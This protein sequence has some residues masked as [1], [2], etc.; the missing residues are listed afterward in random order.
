MSKTNAQRRARSLSASTPGL[1]YQQALNQIR[2][3]TQRSWQY[4]S[5]LPVG[6]QPYQVEA[7]RPEDEKEIRIGECP[8]GPVYLSDET[9]WYSRGYDIRSHFADYS[10]LPYSSEHVDGMLNLL[11][12]VR[13]FSP[14]QGWGLNNTSRDLGLLDGAV[15]HDGFPG[16]RTG[17]LDEYAGIAHELLEECEP[18]LDDGNTVAPGSIVYDEIIEARDIAAAG[19]YLVERVMPEH[20]DGMLIW[21]ELS[22]RPFWRCLYA[23]HEAYVLLGDTERQAN[24]ETQMLYLDPQSSYIEHVTRCYFSSSQ[25]Q[26]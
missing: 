9:W 24:I 21:G 17:L 5:V 19:V 23:L 8:E 14:R 3:E 18:F 11:R 2:Q 12:E 4:R 1:S 22:N 20:F 10:R 26:Q 25:E 16:Y 13:S 7:F 15:A 6:F